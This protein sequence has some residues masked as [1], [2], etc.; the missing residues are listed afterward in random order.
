MIGRLVQASLRAVWAEDAM[1]PPV[2]AWW[3]DEVA[4]GRLTGAWWGGLWGV[5]ST[6]RLFGRTV[7]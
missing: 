1:K 2:E 7:G 4:V 3:G 5:E 6:E